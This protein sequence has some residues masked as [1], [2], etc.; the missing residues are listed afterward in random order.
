MRCDCGKM[1]EDH[2]FYRVS[3]GWLIKHKL[4]SITTEWLP[5]PGPIAYCPWCG[6]K[7]EKKIEP[8]YY[9]IEINNIDKIIAECSGGWNWFFFGTNTIMTHKIFKERGYKI[10]RRL[11]LE[12]LAEEKH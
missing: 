7:I 6:K 2:E 1:P 4:T 10:I 12:K 3:S 8:G 9:L 5:S 11:D